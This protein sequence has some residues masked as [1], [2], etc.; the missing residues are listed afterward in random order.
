MGKLPSTSKKRT[1]TST[2]APYR[3][4]APA[5]P[6]APAPVPIPAPP[7]A[8]T[9][10]PAPVPM[11]AAAAPRAPVPMP[12]P[13][14][15]PMPAMPAPVPIPDPAPGRAAAAPAPA[16]TAPPPPAPAAAPLM[17]GLLERPPAPVLPSFDLRA[18]ARTALG[19][20]E[21]ALTALPHPSEIV[22]G[23]PAA[24]APPPGKVPAGDSRSMRRDDQFA[25]VYRHGAALVTRRG[26]VGQQGV[27]RVVDYPGPTQAAA[28]YAAEC[29]RLRGQGFVDVV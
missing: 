22:A 4:K 6:P 17:T 25:L 7:P 26:L 19:F 8:A 15:I 21:A 20:C 12:M 11:P 5:A 18:I 27:W 3:A 1:R 24:P 23:D 10:P 2:A 9:A 13:A 16:A 14:P 29:S 28:A